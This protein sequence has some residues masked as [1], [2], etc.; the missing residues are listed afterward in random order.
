MLTRGNTTQTYRHDKGSR[1]GE[2]SG[3]ALE[4]DQVV[5]YHAAS[6]GCVGGV[7]GG[8][9]GTRRT[10]RL[11]KAKVRA[12]R[13]AFRVLLPY[14]EDRKVLADDIVRLAGCGIWEALALIDT[15]RA[16]QRL[17]GS[18]EGDETLRDLAQQFAAAL[19]ATW[20]GETDPSR[21]LDRAV[22]RVLGSSLKPPGLPDE[23]V[24]RRQVCNSMAHAIEGLGKG[25][26]VAYHS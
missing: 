5:E 22:W 12:V 16:V 25:E 18:M 3:F 9:A 6:S 20:F 11:D 4:D 1:R 10:I 15:Y 24:F 23:K 2:T 7:N 19:T 17:R 14:A 21:A 13:D 8:P 26:P